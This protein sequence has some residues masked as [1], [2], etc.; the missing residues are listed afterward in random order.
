MVELKINE[1]FRDA[2]PKLSD[3]ELRGLESLI[4]SDQV[5]YNPILIWDDV[6]IDGHNRYDIAKRNN[7]EFTTKELLFDSDE[8]AIIWIKRNAMHQ[9]NLTDLVKYEL[10]KD[11][12]LL[13]KEIG[14]KNKTGRPKDV[15]SQI[16]KHNDDEIEVTTEAEN[17][18][19]KTFKTWIDHDAIKE[20]A[21]KQAHDT[22]KELAKESGLSSGQLA[23]LKVIEKEADEKTK[24]KLRKGETTVGK[25]YKELKKPKI[26][27]HPSVTILESGASGLERWIKKH[28]TEDIMSEYI[29][30]VT[31]IIKKIRA[32]KATFGTA[33]KPKVK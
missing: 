21:E 32:K 11:I 26:E 29:D 7:I 1:R 10:I 13:L 24:E 31:N 23:K 15:L 14:K 20:I 6:I 18:I 16:T 30:F 3:D 12:E 22:R 2:C 19:P 25:V 28:S 4:I 5:I 17:E 27:I 9:R 33:K 8:E